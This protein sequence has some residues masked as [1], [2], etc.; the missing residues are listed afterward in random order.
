LEQHTA[1]SVS[2]RSL[3][4]GGWIEI[5]DF[6]PLIE[7]NDN[8]FPANCA[9]RKWTELSIEAAKKLGRPL[10]SPTW[11]KAQI[12]EAGFQNVVEEK[13]KWPQNKWPRD[14]KMKELG[15]SS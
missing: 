9:V 8:S 15:K 2:S 11:Y 14:P 6:N 4:P 13:F 1:N 7:D 10:D 3:N 12:E 5:Q